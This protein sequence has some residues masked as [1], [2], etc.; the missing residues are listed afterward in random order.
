[1]VSSDGRSFLLSPYAVDAIMCGDRVVWIGRNL[2]ERQTAVSGGHER[3][4]AVTL[5]P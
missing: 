2:V 1:M 4:R 5:T 3:R